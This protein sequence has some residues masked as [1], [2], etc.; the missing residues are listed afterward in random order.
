MHIVNTQTASCLDENQLS[1]LATGL[2]CDPQLSDA[3]RHLDGCAACQEL[4]AVF[5][6]DQSPDPAS[7]PSPRGQARGSA[8]LDEDD[9]D[10]PAQLPRGSLVGRYVVLSHVGSG[11]MGMVYAAY[12]PELERTV[13]LKLLRPGRGLDTDVQAASGRM[14]R[15]ARALARVSH[16]NIVTIHD[17]GRS[18]DQIFLAMERIHGETLRTWLRSQP[19]T[20]NEVLVCFRRAGE[21]LAAVHEAGI[22]HRDFKADNVLLARDGRVLVTDFGLARVVAAADAIE[23]PQS[24]AI[25]LDRVDTITRSE[26]VVGTPAYMA[27]EQVQGRAV[28]ARADQFSF[29]AVLYEALHGER[30]F[31]GRS[32]EDQL[33]AIERSIITPSANSRPVP[34]WVERVLRRGLAGDPA[35]RF[36]SMH[37][38][39]SAL[40]ISPAA[41]WVRRLAPI[42]LLCA[43]TGALAAPYYLLRVRPQARCQAAAQ[44]RA[45]SVYSS[46]HAQAIQHAFAQT[47]LT[48]AATMTQH[49]TA[50]LSS[51]AHA[52]QSAQS[53]ACKAEHTADA[54][55]LSA[56]RSV[57]LDQRLRG[58]SALISRLQHADAR[59]V[60][61]ASHAVSALERSSDC[62]DLARLTS[63]IHLPS[64]DKTRTQVA[65]IR[66]Q[67]VEAQAELDTGAYQAG[68]Q[69]AQSL[70]APAQALGFRPLE[71]DV[72]RLI[73][74]LQKE[75]ARFDEA[76]D[77]LVA[78]VHKG[79]A[80]L[81][82]DSVARASIALV[83]VQMRKARYAEARQWLQHAEAAIERLGGDDALSAWLINNHGN[84]LHAEGSYQDAL[85]QQQRA[86][87]LRQRLYGPAHTEVAM[88]LNNLG[89]T[90]SALGRYAE[91]IE[92]HEQSRTLHERLLGSE[93]P[94][95]GN[96]W[97]NLGQARGQV[98]DIPG[99]LR[100]Y[101]HVLAIWGKTLPADHL[102]LAIVHHNLGSAYGSLGQHAAALQH[103]ATARSIKAQKLSAHHPSVASTLLS[104]SVILRKLGRLHEAHSQAQ[105]AYAIYKEAVGPRHPLSARALTEIG[106]C[107]LQRGLAAQAQ[108]TLSQALALQRAADT[109]PDVLG[110]TEL[111]LAQAL[112]RSGGDRAQA[113]AL[114][115]SAKQTFLRIGPSAEGVAVAQAWLASPR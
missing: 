80:G 106:H 20:L 102:H 103:F 9:T 38:L 23:L 25:A 53:Q 91:A 57:C 32:L 8:R 36:P 37:A 77:S 111:L 61:R 46:R 65:S 29:C 96:C 34:L 43:A 67:L 81:H 70:R 45:D 101:E 68:L 105:A 115:E 73:G 12:D 62:L 60:E 27:P 49:V 10:P 42:A 6:R 59:A 56:L 13:A 99:E 79:E 93:H 66:A 94:S 71:S 19:R 1:A 90:Y 11:G 5:L 17:V 21:G 15:E 92:H 110:D 30:P 82:D 97:L 24:A 3:E 114:A 40:S 35:A 74:S 76:A 104:Q 48:Y 89:A 41:R 86:L 58:L 83:D 50:A 98:G 44:L 54:P 26:H 2:L 52:W 95:V 85:L 63:R 107:E 75:S 31:R 22:V 51:Y 18:G 39:L 7:R 14:L 87:A 47:G 69:H 84:L 28:D 4:L 100:A 16:P 113:R 108:K 55:A 109:E 112:W 33:A 64:D 72:L 78:A 88:S